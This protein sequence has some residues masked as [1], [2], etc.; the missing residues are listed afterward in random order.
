MKEEVTRSVTVL[1]EQIKAK[2]DAIPVRRS[3]QRDTMIRIIDLLYAE[4]RRSHLPAGLY[5]Q[6]PSDFWNRAIGEHYGRGLNLLKQHAVVQVIE[7]Y[8]N[9]EGNNFCKRYRINPDLMDEKV[10]TV[11]YSENKVPASSRPKDNSMVAKYTRRMLRLLKIDVISAKKATLAYV[12]RGDFLS[13]IQFD[14]DIPENTGI[15]VDCTQIPSF[16]EPGFTSSTAKAKEL[17]FKSGM[18]L[19]KDRNHYII[20]DIERYALRKAHQII[21]AYNYTIAKLGSKSIY[22]NRNSTNSRLDSNVTSLP[23]LLLPY[24]SFDG[25]PL[26]SI[27]LSN[28]QF[29]ILASLIESGD[30]DDYIPI[31]ISSSGNVNTTNLGGHYIE[32]GNRTEYKFFYETIQRKL[33][34][35]VSAVTYMFATSAFSDFIKLV[36]NNLN[37]CK[38]DTF[39]QDLVEFV[40]LAKNGKL[41]E[42]IREQLQLPSRSLAKSLMFEV[43]FSSYKYH[44]AGKLQIQKIFPTL[45]RMID[46]FKEINGSNQFAIKLQLRESQIFID[47][48]MPRLIERG[49]KVLS[50]H[51]SILCIIDDRKGVEGEIR[52][53]LDQEI[54][55]YQLKITDA[56]GKPI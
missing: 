55:Q 48:I 15:E 30:F 56:Y 40:K 10:V 34:T 52:A 22:A 18:Y 28:S 14:M 36:F 7:S 37:T 19:I 25:K 21:Q 32:F 8:S 54:G 47:R 2:V 33:D 49:Y 1:H 39:P 9:Y 5:I 3:S 42:H 31:P 4:S 50:K 46:R 12:E 44:G 51:D 43:F 16:R 11:T 26:I 24:L 41:Y 6:I 27:D 38:N 35:K 20:D 29:V 17:A 45:V 53:I 13:K 23:N